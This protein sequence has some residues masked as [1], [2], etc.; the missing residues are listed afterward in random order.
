MATLYNEASIECSLATTA[1]RAGLRQ[2]C[3]PHHENQTRGEWLAGGR[4]KKRKRDVTISPGPRRTTAQVKSCT[5]GAKSHF[6]LPR[7]NVVA[8]RC[9][10]VGAVVDQADGDKKNLALDSGPVC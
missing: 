3:C 9:F 1:T 5:A 4:E 2:S 7:P 6:H 10:G 8:V